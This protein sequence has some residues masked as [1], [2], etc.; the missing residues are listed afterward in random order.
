M[1]V[2]SLKRRIAN[3][4]ERVSGNLV[5]HPFEAHLVTER[6][7]LQ[8]FYRHFGVDCVFDVGA[9]CGQYAIMLREKIGFRGPIISFEPI[10]ELAEQLKTDTTVARGSEGNWFIETLALDREAGPATFN[11]MA[12]SQFSSLRRP[13]NGQPLAFDHANSVSREIRVMRSTI[14]DELPKWQARLGFKRPFLKMDT[15]GNDLA[16]VEGAGDTLRAFVGLQSELAIRTLYAGAADYA[17]T[18]AAYQARGF[19]FSAL[20]PNNA[21]HFP[22]LIEIDCIMYR[23][24]ALPGSDQG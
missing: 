22:T 1:I 8:R 16:V 2:P 6:V 19:E 11:V 21:G 14:A 17:E 5:V 4:I 24:D 18:I 12:D 3:L 23:R 20:V 13:A 15:Q 9:N 7:V 10:P